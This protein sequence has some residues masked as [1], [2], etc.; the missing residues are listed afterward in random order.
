MEVPEG[1]LNGMGADM[2]ALE[3]DLGTNSA[4]SV[5]ASTFT[6]ARLP[7]QEKATTSVC[8]RVGQSV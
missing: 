4:L 6:P 8:V 1:Q 5:F 2:A 7:D 3:R